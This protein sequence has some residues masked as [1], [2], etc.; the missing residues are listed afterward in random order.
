MERHLSTGVATLVA[1]MEAGR[2]PEPD[3]P[4]VAACPWLR[5]IGRNLEPG[6]PS[7]RPSDAPEG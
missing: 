2:V 6:E 5:L 3:R 4:D 1:L 7:R